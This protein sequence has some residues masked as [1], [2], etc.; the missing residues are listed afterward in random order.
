MLE[1]IRNINNIIKTKVTSMEQVSPEKLGL[2]ERSG[3]RLY[4]DSDCIITPKSSDKSLQYYGAFEY[5]AGECRIEM[6]DFVVYLKE[7]DEEGIKSDCRVQGALD[8]YT[9]FLSLQM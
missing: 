5:V 9:D 4:I 8:Y 7:Y 6:G 2:D 3:F 1:F